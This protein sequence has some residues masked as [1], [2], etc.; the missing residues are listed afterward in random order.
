MSDQYVC[1]YFADYI[2]HLALVPFF[3]Q[4]NCAPRCSPSR[5]VSQIAAS[6]LEPLASQLLSS[7]LIISADENLYDHQNAIKE[8]CTGATSLF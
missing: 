4:V 3:R 2:A 8:I 6:W 7:L 5:A 1:I